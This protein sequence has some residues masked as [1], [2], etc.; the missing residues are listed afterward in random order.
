VNGAPIGEAGL[1]GAVAAEF[2]VPVAL[3]T[4]DDAFI[5]ET[6]P[7]FSGVTGVAVKR[8]LGNQV[9]DSLSPTVACTAIE[10]GAREAAGRVA[11]L[12]VAPVERSLQVRVQT[13]S[14]AMADL[15]A[16]LPLVRRLDPATIEFTAP[17]MRHAVRVLNSL[18]AMSFTLR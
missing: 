2:G 1:Y 11:T 10:S 17:T 4:G 5:A 8:A 3:I 14:T 18:S 9:A 15:F 12:R 13:T 6:S 7:L 16:I